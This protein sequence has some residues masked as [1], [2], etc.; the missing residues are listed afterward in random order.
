MDEE[1]KEEKLDELK[2]VIDQLPDKEADFIR[3]YY[4]KEKKQV[5]IAKIFGIT[6]AAVSYRIQRGMERLRFILDMPDLSK[7][8]VYEILLDFMG[9]RDA[10]IF[11]EMYVTSCQ[12]AV[13]DRLELGQ[14]C[15]RFRFLKNLRLFGQK[16]IERLLTWT[17]GSPDDV[18]EVR[19][20]DKQLQ[21][22][23]KKEDSLSDEEFE[24]ELLSVT[25]LLED[26]DADIEAAEIQQ[27]ASLYEAF[28]NIRHNFNILREVKL[29]KWETPS[30][31]IS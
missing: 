11:R 22:L 16:L 26:L 8:E 7:H 3:M 12:T 4:F 18:F 30:K 19:V 13:A 6:Q 15:V 21:K 27:F 24:D 1:W 29:P 25:P 2:H 10:E 23:V 17:S 31:K 28:V 5:D 9:K 20:I 14:G